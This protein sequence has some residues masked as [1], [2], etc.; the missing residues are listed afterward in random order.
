MASSGG[1]EAQKYQNLLEAQQ[2]R[3]HASQRVDLLTQLAQEATAA[4]DWPSALALFQEALRECH[5]CASA[6]ELHK[7]LGMIHCQTGK[8]AS[9][10]RELRTALKLKANDSGA[11]D[12]LSRIEAGRATVCGSLP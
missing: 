6:A 10:E 7:A 2:S 4:R 3:L 12:V 9:G 1:A 5:G 11:A 8:L